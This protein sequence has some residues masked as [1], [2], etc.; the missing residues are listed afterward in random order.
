MPSSS[1]LPK[2]TIFGFRSFVPRS[3]G[4]PPPFFPHPH[5]AAAR[6]P[7]SDPPMV[8]RGKDGDPSPP[9]P[10][11]AVHSIL[12]AIKNLTCEA[13]LS[14]AFHAYASLRLH[15]PSSDLFVHPVSSLLS[16]STALGAFSQGR[17]LHAHV[18]SVGFHE[19][20]ALVSR[21]VSFYAGCN[22]LDEAWAVADGSGTGDCLPW[23]ILISAHVKAGLFELSVV[24]YESMVNRGVA[25]DHFTYPA[26]LKACGEMLRLAHGREVH[27]RI[28]NS[29]LGWNVYVHNALVSMYAR[30]GDLHTA[31][32]LFEGMPERDAVSW[33]GMISA[34][35]S[36]GMWDEAFE[37]FERMKSYNKKL[38]A[39]TLNTIAGGKL[40]MGNHMEA[41]RLI[42]QSKSGGSSLDFVTVVIALNA[43]SQIG[44]LRLGREVH[45]LALRNLFDE[46]E[47][48]RNCLITMYSRCKKNGSAEILF[49][50]ARIRS[51]VTWNCMISGF[52]LQDQLLET[53]SLFQHMVCSGFQPNY[54]TILTILSLCGRMANLQHG[55]ELHCYIIKHGFE[56]LRLLWNSLI[57]MYCK[58]G[59]ILEARKVF[60]LMKDR[61]EVS[62][63]SMI[64]GYGTQGEGLTALSLFNEMTYCGIK[65]DNITMV[66][67]LSACSHA[68]LLGEGEKLFMEMTSVYAMVP[69]LEHYSCMVDLYGRA[70]LLSKAEEVLNTMPI[71]P[72]AELW[73]ALLGA[74]HVC[75]NSEIGGRAASRLLQMKTDNPGHY[76][77]IANMYASAGSWEELAE[78]R[79]LMRDLGLRKPPG[80]AW[81]DL[82][83]GFYPFLV[84]DRD[85]AYAGTQLYCLAYAH[86][87]ASVLRSSDSP[88]Q[89]PPA[90]LLQSYFFLGAN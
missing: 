54:V 80:C 51:L 72:T 86:L 61:D 19:N 44:C 36:R 9:S 4:S 17:Q 13:R 76:V 5:V 11:G 67:I 15:S 60:N 25:G 50:T 56:E 62:Y 83:N 89:Q 53:S 10:S 6:P 59:R 57:D 68:G 39:V 70:G 2:N 37:L 71:Q 75:R 26:V 87:L 23:N 81:V 55:K 33:N 27:R 85:N 31:R 58:S 82:G 40:Q 42:S 69:K 30:C 35:A 21:L 45:G 90:M 16:C 49:G 63:T 65:P 52:A 66:A 20:Q 14:E 74:C 7:L 73:A 22:A 84:G 79:I 46:L 77:L 38:D 43:C 18:L 88:Q 28:N 24:A 47:T 41:L 78:V 8:F 12:N 1:V 34:Y 64:A 48:V 32:E 29:R 3:C